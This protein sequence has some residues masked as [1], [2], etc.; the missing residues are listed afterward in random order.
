[1][2]TSGCGEGQGA[3][4]LIFE[5]VLSTALLGPG[6]GLEAGWS[7]WGCWAGGPKELREG[8]WTD[9]PPPPTEPADVAR[10]CGVALP[11]VTG[12]LTGPTPGGAWGAVACL[13]LCARRSLQC[14]VPWTSE[15]CEVSESVCVYSC[16]LTV[17]ARHWQHQ[18]G[19]G[20]RT[21]VNGARSSRIIARYSIL[22]GLA[23]DG[24]F[25]F[26][27]PVMIRR[28]GDIVGSVGPKTQKKGRQQSFRL[29][30][31]V[32]GLAGAAEGPGSALDMDAKLK[33]LRD[34]A[35]ELSLIGAVS[36]PRR[37]GTGRPC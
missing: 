36:P 14:Y 22:R 10:R 27:D 28:M 21:R 24:R 29:A 12:I 8:W 17:D 16:V 20:A 35:S 9:D 2:G 34:G 33:R 32:G 25:S 26:S 37:K 23:R 30:S 31:R 19:P 1:M 11:L 7:W 18:A 3:G 13:R 4:F 6:L 15:V 5:R